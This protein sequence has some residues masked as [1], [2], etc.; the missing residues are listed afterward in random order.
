[1]DGRNAVTGR[2][3]MK[4]GTAIL[5]AYLA[6]SVVATPLYRILQARRLKS[7]KE[8]PHRLDERFGKA[9]QPRPDGRL[10]WFHAAS[11]GES[12]SLL[13]L[14][15]RVLAGSSDT[16]VLLTT[17]TVT[18]ARLMDGLLPPGVIH[19][20]A[21]YDTR[22]AVRGFLGHW[23]PDVAI[24]TESELWP[25]LLAETDARAIPMLLINA[26]VSEKTTAR[27]RRNP[28]TAR[29]LLS[30]FRAI[31]VQEPQTA[32]VMR[33][34]GVPQDSLSVTG[35]LKEE[36]PPPDAEPKALA[37][38]QGALGA[39]PRWLAAST[40]EGE[41]LALVAAH[42]RAFASA[43]DAPL[44]II[45]PRHP[46]RGAALAKTLAADGWASVLRS[47]GELPGPKTDI[48]IADTLGEMGLWYRLCPI[49]FVGGSLAQIGGHNPYEPAQLGCA[50]IHGP[51]V[52]NFAGIYERLAQAGGARLAK[53][54]ADIAQALHLLQDEQTTA[55][56]TR[57]AH[58]LLASG[59]SATG[60]ALATIKAQYQTRVGQMPQVARVNETDVLVPNFKRRLSGVTAT[61]VRLVP[62][63]A[64]VMRIAAIAPAF[65]VDIPQVR[66]LSLITMS[67]RG[68]SGQRVWHARR[69]VEMIAGLLL[70]HVLRKR[71]KLMFTSASQRHHTGLTRWLIGQ[72]DAVV[73]TSEKTAAYLDR[74]SQ[75]IYHGINNQ[76]FTPPEDRASVRTALG[77]PPD[78][79]L[80]GCYGR[81]RA[82]KGTDLFVDAAIRLCEKIPT[83][84]AVVVGRAVP[85]DEAFLA[86]L[87]GRVH[88]VGLDDRILFKSEVP[89]WEMADWYRA[90]D[91][92]IAPQRWEGFGLTPIEAMACGVP[93][94][95]ADVG[96]F[97]ELVVDGKT[98]F[99][100][101]AGSAERLEQATARLLTDPARLGA[102]QLAARAHVEQNFDIHTEAQALIRLYRTQL[103]NPAA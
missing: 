50:I 25:R 90:L 57:A 37:A 60:A 78:G 38:L 65:P 32:A 87:K 71:L 33:E 36:L 53:T 80:I 92:Y 100:V 73:S 89:V 6:F 45:A 96:A 67:R 40:H 29:A 14:I 19:Q 21:P 48:Y 17:T 79:F 54:E 23:H 88:A 15:R 43:P 5:R 85:K 64:K 26:R 84:R 66:A 35:S 13:E 52:S 82:Q 47:A 10:I 77:L 76:A 63:Q 97:S 74:P 98:G 30:P 7:G 101:G 18:S 27:W 12:L 16:H 24:W 8:D 3:G 42:R 39:R 94:V 81:I 51:H 55:R 61:V 11:V 62:L 102:F 93:V 4:G 68:P 46:E 22:S 9:S 28:E 56:Q 86:G 91:V 72:M 75:V 103:G 95:A 34:V 83:L 49:A 59:V 69:N 99:V 31:L 2:A 70:R 20:F 44:L 58:G 1:M 41:E